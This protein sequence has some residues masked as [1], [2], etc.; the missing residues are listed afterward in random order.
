VKP[1][2]AILLIGIC[3]VHPFAR[4]QTLPPYT[5]TAAYTDRTLHGFTVRVNPAVLERRADC[6]P[7]LE[8]LAE[9]LAETRKLLPPRCLQKLSKVRFWIEWEQRKNGAAE[10]HPSKAWL[11]ANGHNPEKAGDI[12]ISNIRNFVKWCRDDQ[13]MMVLHELAHAYHHRVLG[14]GDRAVLD[15][16]EAARRS[17]NYERVEHKSG[18]KR[19]AYAL[20]DDAEYFAELTEA[21]FGKNDFFPFNRDELKT[22]DPTGYAL[23]EKVWSHGTTSRRTGEETWE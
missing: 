3:V 12:E 15:T 10:F 17:G 20:N 21:Y 22:H 4:A 8:L 9:K 1:A 11:Q 16:Y 7:A 13:P 18:E 2:P 19:R 14:R 5:P 23:M 6:E